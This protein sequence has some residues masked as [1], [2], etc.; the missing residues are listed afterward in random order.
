M[1]ARA[2]AAGTTTFAEG[3]RAIGRDTDGRPV[4][5]V[6]PGSWNDFSFATDPTGARCPLSA[7]IRAVNPRGTEERWRQIARR[8][9]PYRSLAGGGEDGQL[10]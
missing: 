5:E 2:R 6:V 1:A 7:H 3:A 8:G 4:A 9:M 10:F